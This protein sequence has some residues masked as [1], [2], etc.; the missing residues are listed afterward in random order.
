MP[1]GTS[2]RKWNK[3]QTWNWRKCLQILYL[4]GCVFRRDTYKM[5]QYVNRHLSREYA[6][7]ASKHMKGCS[8]VI[9]EMQT[10]VRHH[11]TPVGVTKIKPRRWRAL[12]GMW[13]KWGPETLPVSWG[14]KPALKIVSSSE[15][16]TQRCLWPSN[17]TPRCVIRRENI[18]PYKNL[19]MNVRNSQK[20]KQS[21]CP[22]TN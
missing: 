22:S 18:R 13:R 10:V 1:Q 11:F 2:S 17:S 3:K 21:E 12:V 19:Y 9:R 15:G 14:Y 5:G 16:G 20:V 7:V 6:Q 4:M 8:L